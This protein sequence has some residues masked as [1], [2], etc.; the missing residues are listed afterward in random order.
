LRVRRA[1]DSGDD[2]WSVFN[3]LQKKFI[4]GSVR[5]FLPQTGRR[6][7]SRAIRSITQNGRLNLEL[8]Q[9]SEDF[10]RN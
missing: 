8:W 1:A 7:T 3:V 6:G 10:S 5:Y 2:L 4:R 9:L